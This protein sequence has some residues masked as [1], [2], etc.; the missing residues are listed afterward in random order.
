MR[1]LGTIIDTN[2]DIMYIDIIVSPRRATGHVT[3]TE[4]EKFMEEALRMKDFS[5]DNVLKLIGICLDK[6][7]QL[8]LVVLPYMRHGDLLSYLRDDRNVRTDHVNIRRFT[9]RLQV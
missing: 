4:I 3:D 6:N 7:R 9:C 5:H 1:S 2:G 8:P